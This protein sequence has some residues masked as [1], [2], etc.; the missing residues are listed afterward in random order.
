MALLVPEAHLGAR[1]PKPPPTKNFALARLL[2]E[3]ERPLAGATIRPTGV[4]TGPSTSWGGAAPPGFPDHVLS[5][6]NGAF[7]LSRPEPFI[8]VQVHIEAP[9]VGSG[10]LWLSSGNVLTVIH[11]GPFEM[12]M[13]SPAPWPR[14]PTPAFRPPT[15]GSPFTGGGPP[16]GPGSRPG[17]TNGPAKPGSWSSTSDGDAGQVTIRYCPCPPGQTNK[18]TTLP[19]ERLKLAGLA[20]TRTGEPLPPGMQVHVRNGVES[21]HAEPDS[22]GRFAFNGV[23]A[24]EVT[25]WIEPNMS[26]SHDFPATTQWRGWRLAASNRSRRMMLPRSELVGL[27]EANKEDLLLVIEHAEVP[28][29]AFKANQVPDRPEQRTLWGAETSGPPFIT[30]SGQVFDDRTGQP[31]KG[32]KVI[33]CRKQPVG[34]QPPVPKSALKQVVDAFS[35]RPAAEKGAVYLDTSD[36]QIASNGTFSVEFVPLPYLPLLR[37]EAAGYVPLQTKP[38]AQ[39]TNLVIRL[40]PGVGPAGIVLRTDGQPATGASVVYTTGDS[41]VTVQKRELRAPGQTQ[42]LQVIGPDGKFAFEPSLQPGRVVAADQSGWAEAA[43]DG[44]DEVIKL[45]LKPWAAVKGRLMTTN[46]TPAAGRVLVLT[47]SQHS[48]NG[49]TLGQELGRTTTDANGAFEFQNVPPRRLELQRVAVRP[50][51]PFGPHYQQTWLVPEPGVTNDLGQV[52][53]DPP[54]SLLETLKRQFGL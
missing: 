37:L 18:A 5:D 2:D 54:P 12:R 24:G 6:T 43:V 27:L 30:V 36:D 17:W 19:A 42:A 47:W 41:M 38:F 7:T 11:L 8:R 35:T 4:L 9:G 50:G 14:G 49:G 13:P 20:R 32:V 31:V 45:R 46:A 29:G 22:D 26:V 15:P 39:T 3:G 51:S 33:P 52:I 28:F 23:P 16:F 48:I 10:D 44:A 1:E 34:A 40:K 25:V 53:C 21:E